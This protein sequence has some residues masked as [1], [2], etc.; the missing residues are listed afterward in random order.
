MNIRLLPPVP[1]L[2]G[3]PLS[4]A[5]FSGAQNL[6]LR[7]L[8]S[9]LGPWVCKIQGLCDSTTA[10]AMPSQR[11]GARRG[12]PCGRPQAFPR[13]EGGKVPPKG[14]MRV[15]SWLAPGGSPPK[16]LP[17]QTRRVLLRF[18]GRGL[19]VNR[20]KAERSHP[21]VCPR[22]LERALCARPFQPKLHRRGG[23]PHPPAPED[24][25]L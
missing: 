23:C 16:G 21:E 13:F 15:T 19:E 8:P 14:R 11:Y 22:R 25:S 1:P 2:R 12:D 9:P 6:R 20:P 24:F 3:Y 5:K 10:L 4:Q 18:V 17:T 7:F